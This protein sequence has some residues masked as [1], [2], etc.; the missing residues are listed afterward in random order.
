[1]LSFA[2]I[3]TE[4]SQDERVAS[5]DNN[6]GGD[7]NRQTE[8][9]IIRDVAIHEHGETDG[10][11]IKERLVANR[12]EGHAGTSG[13]VGFARDGA[14]QFVGGDSE[15]Q[16]CADNEAAKWREAVR[17][18]DMRDEQGDADANGT[19]LVRDAD[20]AFVAGEPLWIVVLGGYKDEIDSEYDATSTCCIL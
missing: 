5:Q 10:S 17:D 8:G 1:M 6:N 16:D 15:R 2:A 7:G 11:W 19:N 18:S 3:D 4:P 13:A 12:I 20:L 14:I 9:V